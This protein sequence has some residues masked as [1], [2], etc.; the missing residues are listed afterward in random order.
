MVDAVAAPGFAED[1][2][3]LKI[4]GLLSAA[5]ILANWSVMNGLDYTVVWLRA[6]SSTG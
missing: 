3:P 6:R 1:L 5:N 4:T 2:I